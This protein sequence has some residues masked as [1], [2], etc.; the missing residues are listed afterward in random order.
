[1]KLTEGSPE[2]VGLRPDRIDLVRRRLAGWVE[3][4]HSPSISALVARRGRIVFQE[5]FGQLGPDFDSPAF[6]ADSIFPIRSI[7]KPMTATAVLMLVEEGQLGLNRPVVEYLP[8]ICGKGTEALCVHHLLTHTSGYLDEDLDALTAERSQSYQR[9]ESSNHWYLQMLLDTRWDAALWKPAGEEM[10]Y[11]N[12]NYDLLGEIV[13]RVSGRDLDGFMRERI[14]EPLGMNNTWLIPPES[15]RSRIVRYPKNSAL[16]ES[17]AALGADVNS[18]GIE[19]FPGPGSG[20]YSTLQDLAVF[21]QTFLN[22]GRY[23]DTRDWVGRSS[24]TRS[25]ATGPA[26]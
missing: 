17:D 6:R 16:A 1:M 19:V 10:S 13:Q 14:F 22:G 15:V 20:V 2:E 5:A 18:R 23:G 25:G 4:G 21:G 24:R 12:H 3:E 11:S 7:T 8:E 26:S 9:R